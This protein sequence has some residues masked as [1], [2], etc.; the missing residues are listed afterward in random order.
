MKDIADLCLPVST[1]D[2]PAIHMYELVSQEVKNKTKQL[3][4]LL[5]EGSSY[6][7]PLLE[8]WTS[9]SQTDRTNQIGGTRPLLW[10]RF[11]ARTQCSFKSEI[12]KEA[13]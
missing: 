13:H 9:T 10:Y 7:K 11:L 4:F 2:F 12:A 5:D 6:L 1:L 3:V 8:M